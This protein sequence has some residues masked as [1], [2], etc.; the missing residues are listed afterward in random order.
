MCRDSQHPKCAGSLLTRTGCCSTKLM[1]EFYTRVPC[2]TLKNLLLTSCL[3]STACSLTCLN[4]NQLNVL[5][6]LEGQVH[7]I[8]LPINVKTVFLAAEDRWLLIESATDRC[9][10]S[11]NWN[12]RKVICDILPLLC[13]CM[14][15]S[16]NYHSVTWHCCK[17]N[18]CPGF[19]KFLLTKPMHMGAEESGVCQIHAITEDGISSGFGTSSGTAAVLIYTG[20]L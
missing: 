13:A 15:I 16:Y 11:F 10:L 3:S 9:L 17:L 19:R 6:V 18:C 1:G 2:F 12:R 7:T 14:L 4:R 8:T 20:I 5:D